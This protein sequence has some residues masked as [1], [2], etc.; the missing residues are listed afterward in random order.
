MVPVSL[1]LESKI[2]ADEPNTDTNKQA[3]SAK[4]RTMEVVLLRGYFHKE[5]EQIDAGTVVELPELEAKA[6]IRNGLA[7]FPDEA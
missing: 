1:S 2:M 4:D 3:S 5:G 6:A 7:T